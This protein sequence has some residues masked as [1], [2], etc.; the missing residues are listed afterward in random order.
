ML[1]TI[2]S[3]QY[4]GLAFM[5]SAAVA[6]LR[7]QGASMDKLALLNLMAL[8]LAGKIFYAVFID[9]Y[10]LYF[11]GQYRSWLLSAQAGMTLLLIGLAGLNI[12][13]QFSLTLALF[14][15]FTL[16]VAVQDVAVDGLSCKLFDQNSRRMA[17]TIQ[18]SGNLIGKIVGGGLILM[19]YP[20]LQWQ[21]ALLLIALLTGLCCL[22]VLL[23]KEPEC[24]P[25][26]PRLMAK[27]VN[28]VWQDVKVFIIQHKQWFAVLAI[29]PLGFSGCF[30]L[31]NPILVD[32]EWDL[33]EIGFVIN[34]FGSLVGIVSASLAV[35]LM[36]SVGRI[37]ALVSLTLFTGLSL[38]MLLPIALGDAT[39]VIVYLAVGAYFLC[40]PAL[41]VTLSTMAMDRAAVTDRKATL[42]T[43]QLSFVMLVGFIYS[44]LALTLVESIGYSFVIITGVVITI[45]VAFL[46]WRQNKKSLGSPLDGAHFVK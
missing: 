1:F 24:D 46:V 26:K 15:L 41:L 23:Y 40:F 35:P 3:T 12:E 16:F 44:S 37:K 2:Y 11:S 9:K 19:L 45:V 31:I 13:Q 34:V 5:L 14:A 4:L 30:A 20:Y 6:I 32:N 36:R 8:P 17:N 38:L 43:L 22:Q 39:K 27:P 33:A 18:I 7:E 29:F 28:R 25:E 42:Y 10:R 21:G